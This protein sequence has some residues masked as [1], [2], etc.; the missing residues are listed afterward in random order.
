MNQVQVVVVCLLEAHYLF[1]PWSGPWISGGRLKRCDLPNLCGKLAR[2]WRG[3][4]M[5][6]ALSNLCEEGSGCLARLPA[7]ALPKRR[8]K[9]AA[10]LRLLSS[11]KFLPNLRGKF[12]TGFGGLFT[13]GALIFMM[14]FTPQAF[15]SPRF[16][17]L[18]FASILSS[19]DYNEK[20]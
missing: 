4:W 7:R 3:L 12:A 5:E 11:G 16:S 2:E 19:L 8:G 13:V 6:G 9:L 10:G 15:G 20:P 1:L 18:C 17:V 14:V